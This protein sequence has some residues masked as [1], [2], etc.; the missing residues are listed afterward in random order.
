MREQEKAKSEG[1]QEQG[2]YLYEILFTLFTRGKI[3]SSKLWTS[4]AIL[5]SWKL[6]KKINTSF[7]VL[8]HRK[9]HRFVKSKQCLLVLHHLMKSFQAEKQE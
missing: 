6:L 3:K 4:Q 7:K 9:K 2:I 8:V 1:R 5:S